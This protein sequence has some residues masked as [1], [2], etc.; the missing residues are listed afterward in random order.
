MKK[1]IFIAM[2]LLLASIV[3]A[4]RL[5]VPIATDPGVGNNRLETFQRTVIVHQLNADNE[6]LPV[7]VQQNFN[8]RTTY[9]RGI[10]NS[11]LIKDDARKTREDFTQADSRMNNNIKIIGNRAYTKERGPDP[12]NESIT[13]TLVVKYTVD[14]DAAD[15]L[16]FEVDKWSVDQFNSGN[17]LDGNTDR[18]KASIKNILGI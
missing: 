1:I 5:T 3:V 4:Q 15:G 8:K 14:N 12:A 13:T 2:V 9:V 16:G 17:A 11:D 18:Y 6:T 10:L 7:E